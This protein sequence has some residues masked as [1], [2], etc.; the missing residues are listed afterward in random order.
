MLNDPI[1]YSE[2]VNVPLKITLWT[3]LIR[4]EML[5]T[6]VIMSP[7]PT[8][9]TFCMEMEGTVKSSP[10]Y[11]IIWGGQSAVKSD[12]VWSGQMSL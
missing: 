10:D 5:N 7:N 12:K 11:Q 2:R 9:K 6:I 1:V 3:G 4:I 8:N